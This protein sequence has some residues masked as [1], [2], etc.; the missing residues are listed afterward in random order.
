M[1]LREKFN[2]IKDSLILQIAFLSTYVGEAILLL[3]VLI[4]FLSHD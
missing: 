1:S 4:L 2:R 3:F